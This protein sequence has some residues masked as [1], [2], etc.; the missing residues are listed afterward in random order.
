MKLWPPMAA[1]MLG[2]VTVSPARAFENWSRPGY[3]LLE[4]YYLVS[5]PYSSEAACKVALAALPQ[6]EREQANAEC[7]YEATD[8]DVDGN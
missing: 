6:K 3:Y 5:G 8:P 4:A 1:F 7:V 2:T